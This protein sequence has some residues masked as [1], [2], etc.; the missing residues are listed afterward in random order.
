MTDARTDGPQNDRELEDYLAGR[1]PVSA[2]YREAARETP[3]PELDAAI[4]A[5][6][7][8]GMA[9]RPR[10]RA[11]WR[12][13][14]AAAATMVLGVSLVS[15][16][17]DEA[18]PVLNEDRATVA[19]KERETAIVESLATADQ[20]ARGMAAEAPPPAVAAQAAQQPAREARKAEEAESAKR[21]APPAASVLQRQGTVLGEAAAP[22]APAA[23]EARAFALAPPVPLS[24][25]VPQAVTL[26]R[27][28]GATRELLALLQAQDAERL[29][30][31]LDARLPATAAEAAIMHFASAH[32]A[33]LLDRQGDGWRVGV[34]DAAGRDLGTIR[35]R[36]IPAGWQILALSPAS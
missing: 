4:L 28:V 34:Q 30:R 21:A 1:H 17:R 24:D 35:L 22:V 29:S 9:A 14:L 13:P 32:A 10:R 6:A 19:Q 25:S 18:A 8:V 33:R 11:R 16:L 27:R 2:R 36:I 26:E 7:R 12:V 15:Q 5:A 31:H 23:P 3:P 20:A